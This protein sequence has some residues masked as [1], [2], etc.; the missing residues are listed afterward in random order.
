M[1][2]ILSLL[3]VAFAAVFVAGPCVGQD[4][5]YSATMEELAPS[6]LGAWPPGTPPEAL[7]RLSRIMEKSRERSRGGAQGIASVP[8]KMD[9]LASLSVPLTVAVGFHCEGKNAALTPAQIM[10]FENAVVE[11]LIAEGLPV[12][13]VA[14]GPNGRGEASFQAAREFGAIRLEVFPGPS[15]R[16]SVAV[17]AGTLRRLM[18]KRIATPKLGSASARIV[19]LEREFKVRGEAFVPAS[20]I[21]PFIYG[22]K[23]AR[24]NFWSTAE[25][26]IQGQGTPLQEILKDS[27]VNVGLFKFSGDGV[28]AKLIGLTLSGRELVYEPELKVSVPGLLAAKLKLGQK[29]VL[30]EF[31]PPALKTPE[32]GLLVSSEY[33]A[34]G[35][36]AGLEPVG[37]ELRSLFFNGAGVGEGQNVV[38]T[39]PKY[40]NVRTAAFGASGGGRELY[41]GKSWFCEG[42]FA[43]EH[44]PQGSG[45]DIWY[46]RFETGEGDSLLLRMNYVKVSVSL[47]LSDWHIRAENSQLA[48]LL[49]YLCPTPA[50]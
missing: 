26:P 19:V 46:E 48:H 42:M 3:A 34:Q 25:V 20:Q 33:S 8:V 10:G 50:R 41:P 17:P 1:K 30:K 12:V 47:A 35:L 36:K 45:Q 23:M 28:S 29:V 39:G 40:Q 7:D 6:P 21:P 43:G 4:Q 15:A 16:G 11:A 18:G 13:K 2:P 32:G 44:S 27:E 14:A 24:I 31:S 49:F 38:T 9:P 5:P 37:E 22:E